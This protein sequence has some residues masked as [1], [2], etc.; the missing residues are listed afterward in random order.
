MGKEI[1]MAISYTPEQLQRLAVSVYNGVYNPKAPIKLDRRNMPWLSFMRKHE[2]TA[3]LAGANGVVI[4]WK[5]TDI[6]EL[7]AF[8]RKDHLGFAEQDFLLDG[9]VPWSNVHMGAE[10]VHDDIESLGYVVLPNQARGKNFA[11]P[12]AD[13][14]PYKL[15]DYMT[16]S[17]ESLMDKYDIDEDKLLLTDNSSNVK[18]P[19]GLDAYLPI[20]SLSG[21]TTDP[22]GGTYGYYNQGSIGGRSRAAYADSLQHFVFTGATFGAGGSLRRAMTRARREAELRSRGRSTK[23]IKFAMCGSRFMDKYL[24]F[25]TSNTAAGVTNAVTVLNNGGLSTL[26]I[27]VPDSGIHF[28]GTPLIHNPTFEVLDSLYPSTAIPWTNRCY[29]MDESAFALAYAPGKKKY[30]SAPWDQGDLRVT[31]VSL[32]SKM[33]LLPKVPN[34]CAVVSIDPSN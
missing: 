5:N 23:G 16:E 29:L 13:S 19:Q 21:F 18:A 4:K 10:F 11:K 7:Q 25:S 24:Q 8:E 28:E 12:D 31:R 30:F 6:L 2:E 22:G 27:G 14:D 1:I 3:P 26:D 32:D 15:I 17:I 33:V 34:A 9:T 20:A